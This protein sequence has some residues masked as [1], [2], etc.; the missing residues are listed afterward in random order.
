MLRAPGGPVAVL[1]GSRVTM[2][3]GMAVL[4]NG[5]MDAYFQHHVATLGEAVLTAKRHV[6]DPNPVGTN[7]KLLDLMAAALSPDAGSLAEERAEHIALF[8][9]LGDPLTRLYYPQKLTV[10]INSR[11]SAG[12]YLEVRATLPF[13][14]RCT[15]QLVVPHGT[16]RMKPP[17]FGA[18]TDAPAT[19]RARNNAYVAANDR[20]WTSRQVR[21]NGHA[22]LTALQIPTAA[23]GRCY[24]VVAVEDTGQRRYALGA[25]K[26]SIRAPSAA[27]RPVEARLHDGPPTPMGLS[28][29]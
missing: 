13:P 26:I 15:V 11:A 28:H 20:C 14:G 6:A 21:A 22:L 29:R 18:Y 16:L 24:V 8:N 9:L 27:D 12:S 23:R 25:A 19:R 7:R 4:G 3:Y 1:A 5:L 2:P 10:S 17:R